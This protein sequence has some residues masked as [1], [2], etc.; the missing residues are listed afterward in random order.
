[1]KKYLVQTTL[2][3][4]WTLVPDGRMTERVGEIR[5]RSRKTR[6]RRRTRK[7]MMRQTRIV[8][9]FNEERQGHYGDHPAEIRGQD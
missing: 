5:R 8:R 6:V 7:G 4:Y 3:A 9:E 2:G 1:M